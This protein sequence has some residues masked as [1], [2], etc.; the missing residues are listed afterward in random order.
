MGA[1]FSCVDGKPEHDGEQGYVNGKYLKY[2]EYVQNE[3]TGAVKLKAWQLFFL[4]LC[5]HRIHPPFVV[6]LKWVQKNRLHVKAVFPVILLQ[7]SLSYHNV[8]RCVKQ[9]FPGHFVP[10]QSGHG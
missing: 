7:P 3:I 8:I 4:F 9:I 2:E 1:R 6:G 5:I 10:P